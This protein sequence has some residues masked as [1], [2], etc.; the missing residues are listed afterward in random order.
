MPFTS[1]YLLLCMLYCAITFL[2]RPCMQTTIAAESPAYLQ[3]SP[4]C[5]L[6]PPLDHSPH[7]KLVPR[8]RLRTAYFK[9]MADGRFSER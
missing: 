1:F 9:V 3:I 2:Q 6:L 7:N 5:R 8:H 4:C